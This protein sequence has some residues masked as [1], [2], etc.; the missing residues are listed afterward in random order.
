M[1]YVFTVTPDY[2][3][4]MNL[5][6]KLS[7]YVSFFTDTIDDAS[8]DSPSSNEELEGLQ[9]SRMFNPS[10]LINIDGVGMY[11]NENKSMRSE[12]FNLV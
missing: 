4:K 1:L 3:Q 2:S 7:L 11:Q 12:Y 9:H 5:L 8:L 10:D 6:N